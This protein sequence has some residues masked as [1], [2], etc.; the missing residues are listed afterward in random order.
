MAYDTEGDGATKEDGLGDGHT[1]EDGEPM[2]L[3]LISK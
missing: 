1:K 3:T 2:P